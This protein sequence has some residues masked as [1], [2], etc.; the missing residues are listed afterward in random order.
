MNRKDFEIFSAEELASLQL[1]A[2]NAVKEDKKLH[3]ITDKDK[4]E[5]KTK[6]LS[7]NFYNQ[8]KS[9]TVSMVNTNKPGQFPKKEEKKPQPKPNIT[10]PVEKKPPPV[11]KEEP[12]KNTQNIIKKEE[13]KVESNKKEIKTQNVI[14]NPRV[15]TPAIPKQ[16]NVKVDKPKELKEKVPPNAE[17]KLSDKVPQE[18]NKVNQ[19][20]IEIKKTEAPKKEENKKIE[21]AKNQ[22]TKKEE[23]KKAKKQKFKT[24][25]F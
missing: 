2:K 18:A 10:K 11:K 4:K 8:E 1:F 15:E 9:K 12:V 22:I 24:H 23:K 3:G 5:N 14:N 25:E 13:K 20:K 6:T 21:Q 19:A 7:S 16:Q 17:H